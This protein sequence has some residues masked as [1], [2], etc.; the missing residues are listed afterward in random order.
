MAV[1]KMS[2]MEYKPIH[3]AKVEIIREGS[4]V[5]IDVYPINEDG[6]PFAGYKNEPYSIA[7]NGFDKHTL[8]HLSKKLW[9]TPRLIADVANAAMEEFA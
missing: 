6:S 5:Y 3:V 1:I 2:D 7:I 4:L 8:I 9:A